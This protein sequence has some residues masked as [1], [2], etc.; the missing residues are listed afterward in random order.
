MSLVERTEAGKPSNRVY[1]AIYIH[2]KYKRSINFYV[3]Q[4]AIDSNKE[5]FDNLMQKNSSL[6]LDKQGN[7]PIMIKASDDWNQWNTLLNEMLKKIYKT[8]EE[9][10]SL[11]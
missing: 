8:W 5:F 1:V 6:R 9:Q 3:F 11:D 2:E 10:T 4:R 7:L